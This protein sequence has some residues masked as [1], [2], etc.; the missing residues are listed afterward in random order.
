[1]RVIK[2]HLNGDICHVYRLE[3]HYKD[4][5]SLTIELKIQSNDN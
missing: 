1:M 4:A 3:T 2:E 5:S